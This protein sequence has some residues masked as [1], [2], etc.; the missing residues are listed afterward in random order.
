MITYE[1]IQSKLV[2]AV[3]SSGQSQSEI[4][5]KIGVSESALGKYLYGNSKPSVYTF[6]N[7]CAMLN[8]NPNEI[9]CVSNRNNFDKDK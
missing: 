3:E 8:L 4:A 9:L 1:Q 6:A 2:K 7:L 5:N